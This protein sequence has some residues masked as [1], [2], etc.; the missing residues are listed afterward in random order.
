M[1]AEM[2]QELTLEEV[3]EATTSLPKGKALGHDGLP[4]KYFSKKC[5]KNRP[6]AFPSLSSNALIGTNLRLDQQ[7]DDHLDP[8]I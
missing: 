7:R 8:E 4:T 5:G 6:H 2:T 1:N 3:V